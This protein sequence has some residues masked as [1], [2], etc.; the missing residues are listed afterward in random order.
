M[1]GYFLLVKPIH[2]LADNGDFWR[3]MA[4]AGIDYQEGKVPPRYRSLAR[5]FSLSA[6][7]LGDTTTSAVLPAYLVA[8]ASSFSTAFDLRSLG[9]FYLAVYVGG[10]AALTFSLGGFIFALGMAWLSLEPTFFLHFNSFFSQSFSLALWPWLLWSLVKTFSTGRK[11]YSFVLAA[12]A[13]L[14]ATSKLQLALVPLLLLLA[15]S[16]PPRKDLRFASALLLG[17]TVFTLAFSFLPSSPQRRGLAIMNHYHAIFTGIA[18]VANKPADP[19]LALGI[20]ESYHY[21][22]GIGM[23]DPPVNGR[24]SAQLAGQLEHLNLFHLAGLYLSSPGALARSVPKFQDALA[25]TP[26]QYLGNYEANLP[27]KTLDLPWQ[28][29]NFRDPIFRFI[30]WLPWIFSF[31]LLAIGGRM[32]GKQE[33]FEAWHCVTLFLLLH[34]LSQLPIAVLGNGFYSLHR[35]LIPAHVALDILLWL[36]ADRAVSLLLH[37]RTA[38]RLAFR[39]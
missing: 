28:F 7:H 13:F 33:K 18:Q 20:S 12:T 34:F 25:R 38:Q 14:V 3:V 27:G 4:P 37:R 8:K 36:T 23:M 11:K 15:L 2:G 17:A 35:L 26:L 19:L 30:P 5:E 24:I 31:L 29:S 6:P 10:L 32:V 1:P 21:M 22:A 9:A 39:P 16:I